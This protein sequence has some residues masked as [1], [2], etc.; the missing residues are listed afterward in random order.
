M[1]NYD[2]NIFTDGV[3]KIKVTIQSWDHVGHIYY[4]HYGNI[5]GLSA[6]SFDFEEDFCGQQNDCSLQFDEETETYSAV[7]KNENGDTLQIEYADPNEMNDR[8]VAVEILDYYKERSC[9]TCAE[10]DAKYQQCTHTEQ[11]CDGEEYMAPPDH[12]CVM[13]RKQEVSDE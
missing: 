8:I 13:W 10:W 2:P 12:C 3:H 5:K 6:L 1:K 4:E 9:Y 7:L 11:K